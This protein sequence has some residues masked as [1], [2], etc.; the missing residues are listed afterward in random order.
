MSITG[1]VVRYTLI[2]VIGLWVSIVLIVGLNYTLHEHTTRKVLAQ[3]LTRLPIPP[4]C[5][6]E[7]RQYS[8]SGGDGVSNWFINYN[9]Q[10]TGVQ[11]YDF[12]ISHLTQ[13]GYHA[14]S[15]YSKGNLNIFYSFTYSSGRFTADYNF[16]GLG[17]TTTF[18]ASQRELLEKSP[19]TLISLQLTRN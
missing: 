6:E 4:G 14:G 16:G 18:P 19:V 7:N 15:D 8:G 11:A 2:I 1:K 10:T 17:N 3:E 12:I 5:S 9:C 13:L